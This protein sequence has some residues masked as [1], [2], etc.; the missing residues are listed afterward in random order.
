MSIRGSPP[1]WWYL[2]THSPRLGAP[3]R[4][5]RSIRYSCSN[6]REVKAREWSQL[7]ASAQLFGGALHRQHGCF[8]IRCTRSP[9]LHL[10]SIREHIYTVFQWPA[11]PFFGYT[12]EQG[13]NSRLDRLQPVCVSNRENTIQCLVSGFFCSAW[14]VQP[15]G[16]IFNVPTRYLWVAFAAHTARYGKY[17]G[18]SGPL[19]WKGITSPLIPKGK[20]TARINFG[21]RKS[22]NVNA[23]SGW[24]VN[25]WSCKFFPAAYKITEESISPAERYIWYWQW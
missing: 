1:S 11:T 17:F 5:R 7:A 24:L 25:S 2:T 16:R 8:F 12:T 3:D 18:R 23:V 9:S 19:L 21:R 22:E 13:D 14:D 6:L 15:A 20:N 10:I 4:L